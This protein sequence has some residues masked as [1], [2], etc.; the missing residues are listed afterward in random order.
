MR[1]LY[2]AILGIV[3]FF[4]F[5]PLAYWLLPPEDTV[6]KSKTLGM[7]AIPVLGLILGFLVFARATE[8]GKKKGV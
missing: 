1:T 7:I 6:N 4:A 8:L 3:T 5:I 2:G